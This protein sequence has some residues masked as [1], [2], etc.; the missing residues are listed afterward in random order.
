MFKSVEHKSVERYKTID[1]HGSVKLC[2]SL[3]G[4]MHHGNAVTRYPTAPCFHDP[5]N[6]EI[7]KHRGKRRKFWLPAFSPIHTVFPTPLWEKAENALITMFSTLPYQ[8]RIALLEPLLNC[9]LLTL[10][11]LSSQKIL[12]Y[13]KELT[14]SAP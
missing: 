4:T 2:D 9:R 7:L 6:E 10:S 5:V 3:I 14:L 1:Y 12:L 13:G 11:I 8:R